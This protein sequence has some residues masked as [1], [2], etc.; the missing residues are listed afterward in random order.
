MKTLHFIGLLLFIWIVSPVAAQEEKPNILFVLIDDLGWRDLGCYGGTLIETPNIDRLAS[1]GMRFTDAYASPVCS[2]TRASLISGQNPARNGVWEV[3]GVVDRPHARMKS[4][5]NGIAIPETIETYA[6]ILKK[7]GYDVA[8]VGKWHAGR[9][10]GEEGFFSL[11]S[12]DIKDPE[13]KAY[14][15][16]NKEWHIGE[17]TAKCVEFLREHKNKPFVLNLHHHAVHVPIEARADLIQKYKNKIRHNGIRNI[18]PAYA[19]MVEM[20]DESIGRVLEELEKLGLDKNT[21]VFF[22]SDNGGLV[23]SVIQDYP[24]VTTNLPLRGQKG[25]LYEGGIRVPFIVRWPG[26]VKP[27]TE[28]H[29][30]IN[31]EDFFP[32]FVELGGGK[33]PEDQVADGESLLPLLKQEQAS[34]NRKALYWHFPTSMWTRSPQGAIRMGDY[35]LIE[36][37]ETGKIELYNLKFDLGEQVNLVGSKPEIA[38]QLLD[39]FH[40]WRK[41]VGAA[42][43]TPNPDFDPV[44]EQEMG[45]QWWWKN[46]K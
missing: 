21:V 22:Y 37:Y 43:P 16:K 25:G 42:M 28:C 6:D 8:H 35:K 46:Y 14:A 39:E 3:I 24:L 27:G 11:D 26:V 20:V 17:Y 31:S 2:P 36:D 30:A 5:E 45:K 33:V 18:L 1:Q 15:R 29:E 19:A 44:L 40:R 32:T 38:R 9:T 10:P 13:L 34:L 23:S 4:P 12:I 41:E 7:E